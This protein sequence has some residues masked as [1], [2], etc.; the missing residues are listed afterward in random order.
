MAFDFLLISIK[1]ILDYAPDT[2]YIL[3]D[4]RVLLRPLK[5]SDYEFLLPFALN[6]P[7]TWK[8]SHVSAKGAD[9][10]RQY[11]SDALSAKVSGTEYAFIV[12]DKHTGSMQA[13]HGFTILNP[14]GKRCN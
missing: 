4:D 14:P 3:E 7:D 10:M 8:Y 9:G 11:I 1:M 6:E 2:E 12:F 5:E 13:A